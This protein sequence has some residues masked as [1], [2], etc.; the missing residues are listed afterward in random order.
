MEDALEARE[1]GA[2]AKVFRKRKQPAEHRAH[3]VRMGDAILADER[4]P[5]CSVEALHH[6]D[7][8]ARGEGKGD[9]EGQRAAMI[10]RPAQPT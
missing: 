1:V 9:V 4:Q 5:L 6:Q 8:D 3:H 10:G 7:R 2:L